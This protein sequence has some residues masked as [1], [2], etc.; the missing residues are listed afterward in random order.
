MTE[1]K[2]KIYQEVAK[3]LK[4]ELQRIKL[5]SPKFSMRSFAKKLNISQ[6]ELS[7]VINGKRRP[8]DRLIII[9]YNVFGKSQ[10]QL[11]SDKKKL[12]SLG[13]RKKKFEKNLLR[14]EEEQFKLISDWHNF[15]LLS[16]I[17][18]A[19]F[20]SD[21]AWIASRLGLEID[22]I[23]NTIKMLLQLNLISQD[24][25]GHISLTHEGVK[26]PDDVVSRAVRQSHLNDLT[27]IQ[28][29]LTDDISLD[30]RDFTSCSYAVNMKNIPKL[31]SLIRKFQDEVAVLIE[32]ENSSEVYKMSIYFYPLTVIG[33]REG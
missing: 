8:S 24:Q 25:N 1:E 23:K 31:K 27:L 12:G 10:P 20:K 11:L 28:K 5:K 9:C 15:A 4:D 17:E 26:T 22:I 2:T 6:S 21:E 18:T 30:K 29:T 7:E 16:L 14:I 13:I 33:K 19:D 3:L 32:D